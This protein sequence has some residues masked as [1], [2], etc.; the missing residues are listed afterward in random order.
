MYKIGKSIH[1]PLRKPNKPWG[2]VCIDIELLLTILPY[3]KFLATCGGILAGTKG[4]FHSPNYPSNYP[5]NINCT[6]LI[7]GSKNKKVQLTF[8][9][10]DFESEKY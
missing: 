2:R 9:S 10:F 7:V 3:L 5:E 4:E 8:E 6:W 1:E